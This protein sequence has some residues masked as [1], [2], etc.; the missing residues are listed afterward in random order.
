MKEFVRW[1][2]GQV[3]A[4]VLCRFSGY[5]ILVEGPFAQSKPSRALQESQTREG[6]VCNQM[7]GER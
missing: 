2:P 4:A 6:G 1:S 7:V 3:P 5:Q